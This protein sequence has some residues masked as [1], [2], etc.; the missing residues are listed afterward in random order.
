M[1][2]TVLFA[3]KTDI[4]K[5]SSALLTQRLFKGKSITDNIWIT[6]SILTII[7]FVSYQLLINSWFKTGKFV[8]GS[9]KLALDDIL[10]FMTMFIVSRI[11]SSG[12]GKDS[13]TPELD[14]NNWIKDVSMYISM[15]V[16]YDIL[17]QEH[18]T[19]SM[20]KKF[21]SQTVLAIND[22]LKFTSTLAF[23]NF[24]SGGEFNQEWYVSTFGFVGGLVIYD[25]YLYKLTNKMM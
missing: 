9:A 19:S 25:L 2:N 16:L 13:E 20:N 6:S 22:A 24:V 23:T 5:I 7:G 17:V 8:S 21:N 15:L 11:L 12:A 3:A 18:V 14:F 1:Q 10:K 4:L